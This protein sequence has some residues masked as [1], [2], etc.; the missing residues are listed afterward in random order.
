MPV[1]PKFCDRRAVAQPLLV[2]PMCSKIIPSAV[3]TSLTMRRTLL[4]SFPSFA[5]ERTAFNGKE[6]LK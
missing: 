6:E 3:R 2:M 1:H 5:Q 4:V